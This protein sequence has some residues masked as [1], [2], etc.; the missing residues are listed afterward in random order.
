MS[1]SV[2]KLFVVKEFGDEFEPRPSRLI[3]TQHHAR[4]CSGF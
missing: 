2:V 1:Q 4:S 3:E